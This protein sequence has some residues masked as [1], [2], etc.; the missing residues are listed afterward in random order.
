[1][2]NKVKD[3]YPN[4]SLEKCKDLLKFISGEIDKKIEH[5]IIMY[6]LYQNFSQ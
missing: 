3:I 1:M 4:M 5:F 2:E 6:M